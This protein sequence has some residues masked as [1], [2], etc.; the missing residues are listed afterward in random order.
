MMKY[1][2]CPI[3]GTENH[4]SYLLSFYYDE[5][6]EHLR[7]HLIEL[8]QMGNLQNIKINYGIP[9]CDCFYNVF[10]EEPNYRLI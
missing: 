3:C 10:N 5:S 6:K 9:C 4:N 1:S 8:M 2:N 7:N